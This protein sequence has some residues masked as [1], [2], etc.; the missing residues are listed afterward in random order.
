MSTQQMSRGAVAAA[1][2]ATL[3]AA[4][5][6]GSHSGQQASAAPLVSYPIATNPGSSSLPASTPGIT[7][8]GTSEVAGRPDTLRLDLSVQT[9]GDTVAKAL[10]SANAIT[11]RVQSS[12]TG[13]GVAGKDIQTSQLQVQPEYSYPTNDSPVVKGYTVSEGVSATLRNLGKAGNAISAA[14]TAGG[15]AVQ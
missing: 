10:E 3:G 7:V 13:N 8:T 15:N 2:A 6:V 11:A 14:V 4:F 1:T 5:W 9:R 12:L